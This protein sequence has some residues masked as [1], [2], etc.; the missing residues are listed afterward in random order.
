[1]TVNAEEDGLWVEE[2]AGGGYDLYHKTAPGNRRWYEDDRQY[3]YPI[4]A[5]VIRDYAATGY[6][7]TQNKNW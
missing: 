2:N 7:L 3:L 6:K 1:V 5:K 4:P